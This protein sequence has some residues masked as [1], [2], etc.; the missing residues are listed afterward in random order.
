VIRRREGKRLR[1]HP[2][3]NFI[4]SIPILLFM[5]IVN[6]LRTGF[7]ENGSAG[8]ISGSTTAND[9]NDAGGLL[10]YII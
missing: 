6:I 3:G 4:C 7:P 5:G 10:C 2:V 8:N 9:A 1:L